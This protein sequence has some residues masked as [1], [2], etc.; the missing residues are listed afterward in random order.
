MGVV[1]NLKLPTKGVIVAEFLK[2]QIYDENLPKNFKYLEI[3][4]K[5]EAH[6]K[7]FRGRR[8]KYFQVSLWPLRELMGRTI[9]NI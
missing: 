5:F 9:L 3:S 4:K 8:W 6:L 7:D 2:I 1:F